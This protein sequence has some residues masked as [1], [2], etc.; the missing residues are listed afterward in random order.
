MF[1]PLNTFANKVFSFEHRL[2][3]GINEP[4][5]VSVIDS[6]IVWDQPIHM[7][8]GRHLQFTLRKSLSAKLF[9]YMC[10]L[11]IITIAGLSLQFYM[12]FLN[13]Q[14][15]QVQ[16][17]I[18]IQAEKAASTFEV[19]LDTWKTLVAANISSFRNVEK[20]FDKGKIRSFLEVNQEFLHIGIFSGESKKDKNIVSIVEVPTENLTD[21]RFEDQSP[22]AAIKRLAKN[23]KIWFSENI[24]GLKKSNVM[25]GNSSDISKIPTINMAIR[26]DVDNSSKVLWVIVSAWQTNLIRAL[27]KSKAID[28]Y[29]VDLKGRIFTSPVLR[30]VNK[31]NKMSQYLFDFLKVNE[32][33]P[34]G[35]ID[36]FKNSLE[37]RRVGAFARL[38]KYSVTVLIEQDL[39]SAYLETYRNLLNTGLWAILFILIAIMMAFLGSSSI[40]KGLRDVTLA[41]VKIAS[42]DFNFRIIPKT[43]DE[44]GALGY[45]IN[46]MSDRIVQLMQSQ[47]ARVRYEQELETAK[48]VQSTFFPKKDIQGSCSRITGFYTPASE[49]GGDLWG[50]FKIDEFREFVFVADAM[51]HGAPAALVTAIAYSVVMTISDL[52]QNFNTQTIIEP[53]QILEKVNNIIF[54]AVGGHISMTAFAMLFDHHKGMM[55]YSNAGHNFPMLVPLNP[56]D[57]RS[58]KTRSKS[59]KF[60][61]HATQIKATGTLLGIA[62][63]VKFTQETMEIAVG[64]KIVLYTDGLIECRSPQGQQWGRKNLTECLLLNADLDVNLLKEKILKGAFDFFKKE[65]LADDITV[66]VVEIIASAKDITLPNLGLQELPQEKSRDQSSA[67]VEQIPQEVLDSVPSEMDSLPYISPLGDVLP[68]SELSVAVDHP[69]PPEPPEQDD[70]KSQPHHSHSKLGALRKKAS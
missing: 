53:H 37:R 67:I 41:T 28:G 57:P 5:H 8:G 43:S 42:G 15:A 33:K 60:S 47:V 30:I 40:T 23:Q 50:H 6:R 46:H 4:T 16:D 62:E 36:E 2:F 48:M 17:N 21:S 66:V 58:P 59:K 38:P 20:A 51:G 35:Y 44:V 32:N 19:T 11:V 63:D 52:M 12:A 3:A 18:Q 7:Y 13:F 70:H 69:G 24:G 56:D 68:S 45:S 31:Q 54:H 9:F 22:E 26:F 61:R 25:V 49:C 27:P 10:F 29:V 64:D 39:E 55:T 34:S 14:T 1:C 65:P